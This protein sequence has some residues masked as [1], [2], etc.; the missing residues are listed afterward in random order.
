NYGH[1]T[2]HGVGYFLNVHEGPQGVTPNPAVNFP[3]K[4]GMLQ[5]NEP[6]FYPEG[7]YGIRLENLI[8]VVPHIETEY[9]K[10]LQFETLTLFPLDMKLIDLDMLTEDEKG[11][12]NRY[13]TKVF[14]NLSPKLS[15]EDNQ[16][17][18]EKTREV[19]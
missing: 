15:R 10:F 18:L 3:L 9:G 8:V 13:H 1:G 2:G 12:L 16:W 19:K 14:R 7:K 6:G 5:S 11:W 4:E 17:L